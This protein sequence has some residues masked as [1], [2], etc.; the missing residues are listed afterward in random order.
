M[1][2]TPPMYDMSVHPQDSVLEELEQAS[3]PPPSV[4]VD[5]ND[6]ERLVSRVSTWA[7]S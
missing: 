1:T 6:V 3:S 2:G 5:D 4:Q 7:S